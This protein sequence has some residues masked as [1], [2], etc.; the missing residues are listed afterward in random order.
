M[1]PH[2][3]PVHRPAVLRGRDLG[4][5][6]DR[7][8]RVR[9]L[10]VRRP[11][12]RRDPA[13][14]PR[15]GLALGD[16]P[17]RRR[18]RARGRGRRAASTRSRPSGSLLGTML[19]ALVLIPFV[20]TQRTFIIFGV[21][22]A[23]VG[24][25]GARLAL[26]RAAPIA[27]AATLAIPVGTI[28][29]TED[30]EVLFEKDSEHQYIR[31]IEE[32]DGDRLLELN[33]GQAVHSLLRADS[34]L[35]DDVW[36]GYLVL[37]FAGLD[38]PPERIAI[39]GNAAGTTARS[40][41]EY[42]PGHPDRRRRDRPRARGGRQPVLRHGLE[43]EP[44][45]STPRTRAPGCGAPR[46]ATTRSSSTPTASP[47]SRSTSRRRSSSAL[48]RERL[49]PGGVVVVNAGHPEGNDDL[50]KV[51]GRTMSEV[52]PNVHARPDRAH[53]HAPGRE[54]GSE[55]SADAIREGTR[56][57]CPVEVANLGA[58]EASALRRASRRRRGLHGRP[59]AGRVADRPLDPRVCR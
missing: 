5:R 57:T 51:L 25:P 52:F 56:R 29:S 45:P 4:A 23:L 36:D 19:S 58:I 37:P 31:V 27:A 8:R 42:L 43:R 54:R 41:G 50:E 17:E 15:H 2:A 49:A 11:L 30:G 55:L 7:G 21:M 34:T 33:E 12:P 38:E 46:A 1:P 22:L 26:P 53:Q 28:K 10:A 24:A 14:R 13:R 48:V 6:R 16:P 47:T 9:R 39:L 35:T 32:A 59:R 40:Y 3:D 44:R 20:G 18:R